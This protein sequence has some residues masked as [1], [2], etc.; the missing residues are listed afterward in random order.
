MKNLNYA[1]LGLGDTN[2][3]QFANGPKLFHNKFKELGA[4]CFFGP[5]YADDGTDLEIV[6]EPFKKD[7]WNAL[8]NFKNNKPVDDLKQQVE[9]L[10]IEEHK[11]E[12]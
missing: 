9:N 12:S 8:K 11:Q 3:A 10:T 5:F 4:N 6:V 7:V 1:L 2:Y